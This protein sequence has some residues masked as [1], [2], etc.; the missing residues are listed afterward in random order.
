MC[1]ED[2]RLGRQMGSSETN[3][4][5]GATSTVLLPPDPDRVA[6]TIY[7][8]TSGTVTISTADPVVATVGIILAPGD[9][10]IHYGIKDDGKIVTKGFYGIH[11][12]G[13][14]TICCHESRLEVQ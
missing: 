1:M 6:V 14:V 10:P 2:I 7:P 9:H 5:C 12:V 11:S 3:P 13:G 4:I 8:P